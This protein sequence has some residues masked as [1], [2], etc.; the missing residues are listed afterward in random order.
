MNN[1]LA[2]LDL[3][4]K[5]RA[6]IENERRNRDTEKALEAVRDAERELEAVQALGE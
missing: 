2:A 4:R 6:L 5:A 1:I 3:M